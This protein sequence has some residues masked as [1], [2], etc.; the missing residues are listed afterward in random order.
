MKAGF[1]CRWRTYGRSSSATQIPSVSSCSVI[2]TTPARRWSVRRRDPVRAGVAGI[3]RAR[4]EEQHVHE[5]LSEREHPEGEEDALRPA[6]APVARRVDELRPREQAGGEEAQVL[7][8]VH[9]L[10]RGRVV[11]DRGDVP[12]VD[13]H[14]PEAEADERDQQQREERPQ[15]AERGERTQQE[16]RQQEED[17]AARGRRRAAA[18]A[19]RRRSGRAGACAPRAAPRR[20][21]GR[22]ARRAAARAARARRRTAA[23]GSRARDRACGGGAGRTP[24]RRARERAP[25]RSGSPA[26][27]PRSWTN[28]LA[29][30]RGQGNGLTAAPTR[31]DPACRWGAFSLRAA[32]SCSSPGARPRRGRASPTVGAGADLL[33][34]RVPAETGARARDRPRSRSRSASPRARR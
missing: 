24:G 10:V 32:P 3:G 5:R 19:P 26:A 18:P 7:E 6:Q 25:C 23:R 34:L 16:G 22:A 9:G 1:R 4:R 20:R 2:I 8:V 12:G 13:G 21:G 28:G 17:A 14:R 29:A 15:R 27:S 30:P 11:V 31:R 33:A